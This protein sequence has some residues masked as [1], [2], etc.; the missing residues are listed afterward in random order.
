MKK[1]LLALS[2]I[3]SGSYLFAQLQISPSKFD[4]VVDVSIFDIDLESHVTNTGGSPIQVEWTRTVIDKAKAWGTYV[5]TGINCYPPNI[6][7]GEFDLA[8]GASDVF[9]MHFTPANVS[10]YAIVEIKVVEKG[11]PSN[12]AIATY[13]V[14]GKAVATSSVRAEALRIY[15]NPTTEYFRIQNNGSVAKVNILNLLGKNIKSYNGNTERFDVTD[16][17]AGMYIVQMMDSK[18]KNIKTNKLS[19]KKP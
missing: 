19:I 4:T 17:P 16:L 9:Q 7:S 15:P 12:F 14:S 13:D 1:V 2:L 18:G 6:E 8:P 11:N 10:G 3:F 5:C